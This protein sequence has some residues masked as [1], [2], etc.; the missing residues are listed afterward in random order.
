MKK[1]TYLA[2]IALGLSFALPVFAAFPPYTV[3][4]GGTGWNLIQS[5][6][7]PFGDTSLRLATSSNFSYDKTNNILSLLHLLVTGSSTFQDFTF[8]SATGTS[9]TSTN[10]FATTASSTNLFGQFINGFGLT[11]CNTA[12]SSALTWSAGSFGCNTISAGSTGNVATSSTETSGY[13]PFWTSTGAT[14]ATLSG[15]VAGFAFDSS[16]VKLTVTNLQSTNSTSTNATSTSLFSTT[17]SSTSLFTSTLG[18]ATNT[19][20]SAVSVGSGKAITVGENRLATS[21]S[22]TVDWTVGNQQLIQK[23]T[24][25][26]TLAFSNVNDGAKLALIGCNPG[27]GTAGTFTWP[28]NVYWPGGTAPTQTT[29][30]NKCDIYTFLATKATST[31]A[32]VIFGG[33]NQNY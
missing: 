30:A 12:G 16:L 19:P 18:V 10:F 3:Q 11:T 22:M 25:G 21:T 7:V 9:A 17:A 2:S 26:I 32:I 5:S 33:F 13:V 1:L 31:T 24:A 4:Q 27:S 23:G 29:T 15:G 28:S 20:V 8:T 14:P 6:F